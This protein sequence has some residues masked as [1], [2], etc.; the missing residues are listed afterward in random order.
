MLL[1]VVFDVSERIEDFLRTKPPLSAILFDYYQNFVYF[2]SNLFSSLIVFISVIF[3][4]SK[5]AQNSEVIA[6]LSS[7][8]SFPRF[9]RP[10]LIAATVLTILSLYSN[11]FVLPHANKRLLEFEAKY[12]WNKPTYTRVHR[13]MENGLYAFINTYYEG[14]VDYMWMEKWDGARLKSS[15]YASRAYCDTVSNK[16]RFEDYFQREFFDGHEKIKNGANLDT[17]LSFNL[18]DFG[19]RT[20]WK[21]AMPSD[22]LYA[23][24]QQERERGNDDLVN[25][26]IEFHQRTSYPVATYILTII[27]VCVSC[28]K[29]RGG[30]GLHLMIGLI[31][32]VAYIFLMKVTSVAATNAGV[33][34][35]IA[36]WTPNI[37]FAGIGIFF[38]RWARR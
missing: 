10:Y 4:T 24:I 14:K 33:P 17:V 9:L 30:I 16:W 38:Y 5:L 28:R 25:Y 31:V 1:A 20:E 2:Y 35:S 12:V 6:I 15:F 29:T 13:E 18:K 23:Y 36:V 7:G 22:E 26:E 27:A 34:P 19:L 11:H 21:S 3:F 8:I 37:L 32:A